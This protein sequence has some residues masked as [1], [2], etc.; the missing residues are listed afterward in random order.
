MWIFAGVRSDLTDGAFFWSKQTDQSQFGLNVIQ[1][2][3]G[4]Q[5]LKEA[6]MKSF[7]WK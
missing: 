6:K 2:W 1:F 4:A 5:S 3:F 7:E